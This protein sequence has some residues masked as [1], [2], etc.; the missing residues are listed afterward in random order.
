MFE[1]HRIGQAT[2]R[3]LRGLI[4]RASISQADSS[5]GQLD[6]LV[7]RLALGAHHLQTELRESSV[8]AEILSMKALSYRTQG[9]C[10]VPITAA[11]LRA[12]STERRNPYGGLN[13]RVNQG[14]MVERRNF[15][16]QVGGA[17]ILICVF[18]HA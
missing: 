4:T 13:Y 1:S 18:P 7:F 15:S 5:G 2:W 12:Y 6:G 16:G 14:F 11:S 3:G 8:Y 17:M 9:G 10:L